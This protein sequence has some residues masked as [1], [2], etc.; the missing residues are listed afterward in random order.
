MSS[1]EAG[2]SE[3]SYLL[4]TSTKLMLWAL[5]PPSLS[6]LSL[7]PG[8]ISLSRQKYEEAIVSYQEAIRIDPSFFEAYESKCHTVQQLLV[9]V[10][11]VAP[12]L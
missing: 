3:K 7:F 4:G 11:I 8:T 12:A 1:L 9:T 2:K 10:C 6:S 5:S